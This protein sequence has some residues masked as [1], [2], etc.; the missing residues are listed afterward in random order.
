MEQITPQVSEVLTKALALSAQERGL[1]IDQVIA[2]LD[3]SPAE[4]GAEETWGEE[5]RRRV[6]DIRSGKV[7][8]IPGEQLLRELAQEFPDEH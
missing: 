4:D 3:E 5:I 2:S 6:E 1:L 8:M 7:E